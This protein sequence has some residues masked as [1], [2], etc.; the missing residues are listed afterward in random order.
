M[1]QTFR[2]SALPLFVALLALVLYRS[3]SGF[4]SPLPLQV[5]EAQYLGW[6]REPDFGYYSKPPM[7]AWALGMNR[8]ACELA[9]LSALPWIEGCARLTQAFA[10]GLAG[11]F[12]ALSSWAL[13]HHKQAAFAAALL[14]ITSPLFGFLS[15]F[16]TTDAW[17]LMFWSIALWSFIRGIGPGLDSSLST[18]AGARADQGHWAYWAVCGVAVGLGLLS[19]YSMGVFVVSAVIVLL[20][21]RRLFSWGPW[22]AAAVAFTVFMPNLI[23]NAAQGF[24]TLSHHLEISQVQSLTPTQWSGLGAVRSLAEFL[25]A[26]LV[27]IGPFAVLSLLL[28]APAYLRGQQTKDRAKLNLLW[29]FA[30]PML[31]IVL[32]QAGLSRAFANWAAPAY[33]ALAILAGVLWTSSVAAAQRPSVGRRL[34]WLSAALGLVFSALMIHGLRYAYQENAALQ[35]RAVEKL[36]GWKEAAIWIQ[37]KARAHDA[38]VVAEDRRLLASLSGYLGLR[39]YALDEQNRRNHHYSWFYHLSDQ[40]LGKDQRILVVLVGQADTQRL[41]N[42]LQAAGFRDV[43]A[44]QASDEPAIGVGESGD[45]IQAFWAYR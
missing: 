24:P 32:L 23:W 36:R 10:L 8:A 41:V 16:A 34:L 35:I 25:A 39:A 2:N 18:S 40:Q 6:S 21:L 33:L 12:A 27:L 17:L 22:L 43:A 7:I 28:W 1:S 26:Q 44:A 30:L 4:F 31:A 37:S 45:K 15:L 14:L 19:K 5:D 42:R 13:F 20:A 11:L 38:I 9:G 3:V 29:W